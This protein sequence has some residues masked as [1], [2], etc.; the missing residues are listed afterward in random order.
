MLLIQDD[1]SP[2]YEG[3]T[4]EFDLYAR[5]IDIKYASFWRSDEIRFVST[6]EFILY[7]D[8]CDYGCH[9]YLYNPTTCATFKRDVSS[10][11]GK[12]SAEWHWTTLRPLAA[13]TVSSKQAVSLHY[14]W[15]I[16]VQLTYTTFE[17]DCTRREIACTCTFSALNVNCV[18][19]LTISTLHSC[20]SG[21]FTS[22]T[23]TTFF[24]GVAVF[25]I[26]LYAFRKL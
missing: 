14:C 4:Q 21:Q 5:T 16:H 24:S 19:C 9:C 8:F 10:H 20:P 2:C 1:T 26:F 23:R 15:V 3:T 11:E 13:N 18:K 6:I 7:E 17:Y 12:T 25:I 22:M